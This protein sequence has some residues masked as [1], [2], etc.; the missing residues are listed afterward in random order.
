MHN[1]LL[2]VFQLDSSR[3]LLESRKIVAQGDP[4]L[5]SL[6]HLMS[7]N[8]N[9][10]IE[11]VIPA[12]LFGGKVMVKRNLHSAMTNRLSDILLGSAIGSALGIAG[13]IIFQPSRTRRS[14]PRL[15]DEPT[16]LSGW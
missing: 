11:K 14:G 1:F 3:F 10:D 8:P 6:P 7:S 9:F 15:S 5:S 16:R 2:L 13:Y 4:L 12:S